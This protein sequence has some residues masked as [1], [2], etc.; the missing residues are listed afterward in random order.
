MFTRPLLILRIN[1]F[2]KKK[3]K[4]IGINNWGEHIS[5]VEESVYLLKTFSTRENDVKSQSRWLG[6]LHMHNG[7]D[8]L[9]A[10][11]VINWT[12]LTGD[13]VLAC[14]YFID[15]EWF[16][17]TFGRL[18]CSRK[19]RPEKKSMSTA[20]SCSGSALWSRQ[21]CVASLI[22]IGKI[23]INRREPVAVFGQTLL[24]L[25]EVDGGFLK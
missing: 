11:V 24:I 19:I 7:L 16:E 4:N 25:I 10:P 14:W 12:N 1:K 23:M 15:I 9:D 20:F 22:L 13:C 2:K 6:F 18:I 5:R 3:K 17:T 8:I 21:S